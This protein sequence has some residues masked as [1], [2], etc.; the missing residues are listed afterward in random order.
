MKH[1]PKRMCIACR[2]MRPQSELIRVVKNNETGKICL[3]M[4]KKMFGR[5]A[6]ICNNSDCVRL[7]QKKRGLER[8][9]KCAVDSEIYTE[10]MTITLQEQI[11]INQINQ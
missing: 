7:A 1:V 11:Q 3:D 2:T 5:G 10:A 9:F 4:K 8:H 6:Y